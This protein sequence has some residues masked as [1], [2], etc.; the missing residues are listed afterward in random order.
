MNPD[1]VRRERWFSAWW[2]RLSTTGRRRLSSRD[3]GLCGLLFFCEQGIEIDELRIVSLGF[4][5]SC[6]AMKM[7]QGLHAAGVEMIHMLVLQRGRQQRLG[8]P[9]QRKGRN[10]AHLLALTPKQGMQGVNQLPV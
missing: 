10:L 5:Y 4:A 1:N 9:D 6:A 3:V 7:H 8:Q 2:G